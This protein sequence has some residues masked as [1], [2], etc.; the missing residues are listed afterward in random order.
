MAVYGNLASMPVSELLQWLGGNGKTGMV[1]VER[2]GVSTKLFFESGHVVACVS[3]DPRHLLGQFLL[4]RDAITQTDLREAMA[5]Q[6]STGR[7]L[8]D[9]LI[10]A[11]AISSSRLEKEVVAKAQE[12]ILALFEWPD[13][14]FWY[15]ECLQ[16]D[17][18]AVRVDLEVQELL[19]EGMR[20]LDE[21][22]RLRRVFPRP[23]MV[24]RRGEKP[25][26]Q[27]MIED[28][29]T[30][31]IYESVD[32]RRSLAQIQLLAH[33]TEFQVYRRLARLLELGLVL[34]ETESDSDTSIEAGA[35]RRPA[36]ANP[37]E[38]RAGRD[39]PQSEEE[40]SPTVGARELEVPLVDPAEGNEEVYEID[41]DLEG[42]DL[43]PSMKPVSADSESETVADLA[44]GAETAEPPP[45]ESLQLTDELDTAVAGEVPEF[46]S[47][48]LGESTVDAE[49]LEIDAPDAGTL[50][51]GR[52]SAD[53]PSLEVLDTGM[54]LDETGAAGGP[55]VE[56]EATEPEPD[57]EEVH[58]AVESHLQ[59][60]RESLSR[61][62]P[63][64]ALE[65]LEQAKAV[66][67]GHPSIDAIR[68]Q[69]EAAMLQRYLQ[70]GI[71]PERRPIVV[72]SLEQL[73][74]AETTPAQDY[75][76]GMADG[77][78]DVRSILS[79]SPLR[80]LDVMQALNG[81]L[82][83]GLI[84]LREAD[85]P[86]EAPLPRSVASGQT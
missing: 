26:P 10:Q 43:A 73:E 18:K 14:T 61:S 58:A 40:T 9:I 11:G 86:S 15:R 36:I 50:D 33:G 53:L 56:P 69:S 37:A 54:V 16:A 7:G 59:L 31:T 62:E 47:S 55:E 6:D 22:A 4:F 38:V 17:D 42:L 44:L 72:A 70:E 71:R 30:R 63:E 84:D 75:L 23:D 27:G 21:I 41:L 66:G 83:R 76:L 12:T 49:V 19:L 35:T 24:P 77:T 60:A 74:R 81:L 85:S 67:P 1:R 3:D 45:L 2:E 46:Q 8:P 65:Q 20:R 51:P 68:A 57:F 32:G 25:A 78:W 64:A 82:M 13:A 29:A 80:P 28:A 39:E 48:A 79:I 5:I 52:E 34:L